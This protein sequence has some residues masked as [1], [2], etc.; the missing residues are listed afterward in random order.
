MQ[1]FIAHTHPDGRTK[2]GFLRPVRIMFI[3]A[4]TASLLVGWPA[5]A[6]S[7]D[8]SKLAFDLQPLHVW[9]GFEGPTAMVGGPISVLPP[10]VQN[11]ASI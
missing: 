2:S 3:A 7:D 6:F 1:N 9:Q 10:D 11:R 4:I 8:F 5:T